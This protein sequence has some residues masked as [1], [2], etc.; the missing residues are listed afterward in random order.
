MTPYPTHHPTTRA[1]SD[2]AE[3]EEET[4]TVTFPG[5]SCCCIQQQLHMNKLAGKGI[6][7]VYVQ[8]SLCYACHPVDGYWRLSPQDHMYEDGGR[9]AI[10]DL[11]S[12]SRFIPN[13][14]Y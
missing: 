3:G 7:P 9:V 12:G 1:T 5:C 14:K 8:T 4:R 10:S 2:T 11:D 13:I 6:R